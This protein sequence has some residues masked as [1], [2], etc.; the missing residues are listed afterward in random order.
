VIDG[1]KRVFPAP[2]QATLTEKRLE[3][4]EWTD[5]E[6]SKLYEDVTREEMAERIREL[7]ERLDTL[8]TKFDVFTKQVRRDLLE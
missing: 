2:E 6:G 4:F 1:Q 7:E 8:E 5:R 3:Y